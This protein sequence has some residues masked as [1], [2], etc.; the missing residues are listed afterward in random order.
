MQ[1]NALN[2]SSNN[3]FIDAS[4]Y[5]T[6][7]SAQHHNTVRRSEAS[8]AGGTFTNPA[9]DRPIRPSSI[10]RMFGHPEDHAVG[11]LAAKEANNAAAAHQRERDKPNFNKNPLL[12][13]KT[14]DLNENHGQ[15]SIGPF[16][17]STSQ[18]DSFLDSRQA[19]Q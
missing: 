9:D 10:L 3:E 19:K 18:R 13:K 11:S 4:N 2:H 14:I 8:F 17:S 16:P 1:P 6:E 15:E 12:V 5:R 7:P